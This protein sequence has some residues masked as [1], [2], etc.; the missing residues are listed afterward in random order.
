MIA[1]EA[2]ILYEIALT[3]NLR[4]VGGSVVLAIPPAILDLLNLRPGAS[5]GLAVDGSRL[6]IGAQPQPRYTLEELLAVSDY[7][8]P[9]T[10][11]DREW[12]DAPAAGRELI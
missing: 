3:A 2:T 6:V 12:V 7:T 9:Q 8:Q 5:V 4:K 11:E 1:F 10:E